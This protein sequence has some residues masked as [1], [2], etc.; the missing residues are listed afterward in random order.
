[1]RTMKIKTELRLQRRGMDVIAPYVFHLFMF[2]LPIAYAKTNVN[3]QLFV[4]GLFLRVVL[5]FSP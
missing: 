4:N 5:T 2:S 1:M 3:I